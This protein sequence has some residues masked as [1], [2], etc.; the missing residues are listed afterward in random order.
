M[1]ILF[2]TSNSSKVQLAN[3]RLK[4][5]GIEVEQYR[6]ELLEPQAFDVEEVALQKARQLIDSV[7]APF[8]VEDSGLYI[9]KLSG[10][11]G[12]LMKPVLD[13]I[14]E[15]GLIKLMSGES[16]RCV[17]VKSV[18][19]YC[20]PSEKTIKPF[21]GNYK[22]S[23]ATAPVGEVT[24]G[25]KVSRIFIPHD[26]RKTLAEMNDGEW[27]EFLEDFKKDDHYEKFGR[28]LEANK[29]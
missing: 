16:Y 26:G 6:A 28:W 17:L 21:T 12:A 18:L 23:L 20:D 9:E 22:G 13:S 10:F 19:V 15:T 24:R 11:P 25:W 5:Y 14:G 2:I 4:R 3:E 1:K 29:C 8:V 27:E 7:K